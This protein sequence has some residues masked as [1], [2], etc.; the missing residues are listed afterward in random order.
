ML[1]A[2]ADAISSC[3]S[4][5]QLNANF[6]VPSVFDTQVVT[7]VAEAIKLMGRSNS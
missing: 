6:I 3:V 1:V 7:K 5:D 4:S 2:A